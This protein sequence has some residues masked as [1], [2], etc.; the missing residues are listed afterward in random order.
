[1]PMATKLGRAVAFAEGLIHKIKLLFGHIR[2][3]DKWKAL[4]GKVVALGLSQACK[5]VKKGTP[6][7]GFFYDFCEIFKDTFFTEHLLVA[8]SVIIQKSNKTI[9]LKQFFYR[10]QHCRNLLISETNKNSHR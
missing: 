2:S 10:I 6:I 1:M 4:F 9:K 7:Q 8:A 3:H 5:F